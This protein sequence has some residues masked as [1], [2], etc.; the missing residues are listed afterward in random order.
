MPQF[1]YVAITAAGATV[2]GRME[3]RDADAVIASL[4]AQGHLPVEAKPV[5][6]RPGWRE[7]LSLGGGGAGDLVMAT[8]ELLLLLR[9]GQPLER[10]LTLLAGGL[11]PRPLRPRFRTVLDKVRGGAPLAEAM[12]RAGGFPQVY[13]A[14][15]RAGEAGGA[16]DTALDRLA[17]LLERERR[18]KETLTSAMLYP[19]VLA[20]VAVASIL[21]MLLHVVPQFEHL[22]AGTRAD[23]P[24]ITRLVLDASAGLRAHWTPLMVALLVLLLGVRLLGS[25]LDLKPWWERAVLRLPLVGGLVAMAATARLARTLAV[26]LKAGSPLPTA[27]ALSAQA[28][29]NGPVAAAA[30]AMRAGVKDGRPLAA[31]LPPGHPLPD[32][33]VELIK[34]GEESGRLDEVLGHVAD[35]YDSKVEVSLKRLLALVEPAAVILLAL[36]IGGIV[37][38]IMLALV[39][40]NA[41][42]L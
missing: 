24:W 13:R 36:I 6:D 7:R 2:Q 17:D 5:A 16:L 19:A 32:L 33:A 30:D 12:E 40:V 34:V 11:A 22:F 31:S 20:V 3:A 9:A 21:L 1:R 38:S 28:A 37:V 14:M 39:S 41:L 15:V 23:L 26:L 25:R 29:G 27:L 42:A 10:A 18:M 4:R 35:V 8:R